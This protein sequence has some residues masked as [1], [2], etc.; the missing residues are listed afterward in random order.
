MYFTSNGGIDNRIFTGLR[1][2]S[3]FDQQRIVQNRNILFLRGHFPERREGIIYSHHVSA[4]SLAN[5]RATPITKVDYN[6]LRLDTELWRSHIFLRGE[7]RLTLTKTS[8][9]IDVLVSEQTLTLGNSFN[10]T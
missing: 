6:L 5:S 8:P 2:W 9:F 10:T 3:S 1:V 7:E 4:P